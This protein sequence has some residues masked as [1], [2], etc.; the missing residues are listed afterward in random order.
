MRLHYYHPPHDLQAPF[1]D[2]ETE[3]EIEPGDDSGG[4]RLST[5]KALIKR[6]GDSGYT[7]SLMKKSFREYF[8]S[9]FFI[10]LIEIFQL[11]HRFHAQRFNKHAHSTDLILNCVPV[12]RL[13]I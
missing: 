5:V 13:G 12:I 10:R 4:M 11:H 6:Y 8:Y 3:L 7:T 1:S 9:D 2:I